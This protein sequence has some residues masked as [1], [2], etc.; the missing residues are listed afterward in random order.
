VIFNGPWTDRRYCPAVMPKFDARAGA[1]TDTLAE[2]QYFGAEID[3]NRAAA[4]AALNR[5]YRRLVSLC[6]GAAG[7]VVGLGGMDIMVSM[8]IWALGGA[9]WVGLKGFRA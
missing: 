5:R 8:T 4:R 6:F 2:F 3:Q 7:L 9:A 1:L